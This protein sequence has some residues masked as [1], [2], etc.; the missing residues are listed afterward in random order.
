MCGTF[1][2]DAQAAAGIVA[3]D[4]ISGTASLSR[5][6]AKIWA[7][8]RVDAFF[9]S[10][11]NHRT[12]AGQTNIMIGPIFRKGRIY[13]ANRFPGDGAGKA[14]TA[15]TDRV[16]EISRRAINTCRPTAIPFADTS[17]RV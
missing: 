7:V 17:N 9:Q 14:Q 16:I 15:V 4:K 2:A 3:K 1:N 12:R 11:D 8:R 10:R 13:R 5:Q 6:L